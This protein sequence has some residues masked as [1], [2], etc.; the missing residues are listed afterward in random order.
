[1]ACKGEGTPH[2]SG[3]LE[4]SVEGELVHSKDN[5]DGYID[6]AAKLEKIFAAV[7]KALAA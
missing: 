6:S 1:M 3:Y 5:G 7:E 4:V 2:A